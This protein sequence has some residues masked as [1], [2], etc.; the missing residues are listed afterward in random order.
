MITR[1]QLLIFSQLICYIYLKRD[2]IREVCSAC[3]PACAGA[4][5][6]SGAQWTQRSL[7]NGMREWIHFWAFP[8]QAELFSILQARQRGLGE[9]LHDCR[10]HRA[11]WSTQ[12]T[13]CAMESLR[14]QNL[15]LSWHPGF[16]VYISGVVYIAT[17]HSDAAAAGLY[18]FQWFNA[19]QLLSPPPM[20]SLG[21]D[22]NVL[23]LRSQSQHVFSEPALNLWTTGY[24][25]TVFTVSAFIFLHVLV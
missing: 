8:P 16:I 15:A 20:S 25:N 3:P 21:A 18:I 24:Q 6:R 11:S 22:E 17:H 13:K 2:Q 7:W 10:N 19:V 23:F 12:L 4:F 14:P 9:S 1:S 5:W